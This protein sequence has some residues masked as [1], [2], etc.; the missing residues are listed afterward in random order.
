MLDVGCGTGLLAMAARRAAPAATVDAIERCPAMARVAA[1]TLRKNGVDGVAVRAET[2][3][4][5]AF[6]VREAGV[7]LNTS[8]EF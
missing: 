1:A 2:K 6:V 7:F 5:V 4:E 3:L 8:S